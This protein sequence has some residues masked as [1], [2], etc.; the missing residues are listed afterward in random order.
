MYQKLL[1]NNSA[2]K[3]EDE[4]IDHVIEILRLNESDLKNQITIS[5]G[6]YVKSLPMMCTIN[7]SKVKLIE[8]IISNYTGIPIVEK[9]L[10]TV[11]SPYGGGFRIIFNGNVTYVSISVDDKGR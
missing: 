6:K 5:S 1:V 9:D 8:N 2:E 7:R 3:L 10:Y 11:L 4:V